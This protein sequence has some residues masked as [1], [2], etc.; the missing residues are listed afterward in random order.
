[1]PQITNLEINKVSQWLDSNKLMLIVSETNF[2]MLKQEGKNWHASDNHN[3][4]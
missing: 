3:R 2:M 4:Q 1:M